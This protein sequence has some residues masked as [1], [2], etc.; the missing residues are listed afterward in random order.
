MGMAALCISL[1]GQFPQHVHLDTV[2]LHLDTGVVH[3]DTVVPMIPV[4]ISL[5]LMASTFK[6]M[7]P[8]AS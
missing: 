7:L 1:F 5:L 2:V 3:L 8:D 4:C 6:R